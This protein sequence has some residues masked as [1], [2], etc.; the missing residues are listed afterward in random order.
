MVTSIYV[1]RRMKLCYR[2]VDRKHPRSVRTYWAVPE[3][4]LKGIVY[5]FTA[6]NEGEVFTV[7]HR[8][9]PLEA[10]AFI[11]CLNCSLE[12]SRVMP[13]TGAYSLV[14]VELCSIVVI[15]VNCE[16]ILY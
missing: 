13:R 11:I 9:Y 7:V 15:T 14:E 3:N 4:S 1:I 8:D 12:T 10:V 2:C 16:Y 5:V 6:L